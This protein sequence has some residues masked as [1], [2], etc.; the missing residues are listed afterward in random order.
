MTYKA[1]RP[2]RVSERRQVHGTSR[3]SLSSFL[4]AESS[5]NSRNCKARLRV[6]RHRWMR[7]GSTDRLGMGVGSTDRC[8][9]IDGRNGHQNDRGKGKT[10]RLVH[11]FDSPW[12][13][14]R[15]TLSVSVIPHL[16]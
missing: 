11:V 7:V 9:H 10:Q 3:L 13:A 16:C 8:I 1:S 4:E 12:G 15:R 14:Y 6:G 5:T 2:Q